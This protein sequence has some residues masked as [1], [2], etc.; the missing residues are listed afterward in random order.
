MQHPRQ[1]VAE[2][3]IFFYPIQIGSVVLDVC[4]TGFDVIAVRVTSCPD[5]VDQHARHLDVTG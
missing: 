1:Q 2:H 3:W 5:V 4:D